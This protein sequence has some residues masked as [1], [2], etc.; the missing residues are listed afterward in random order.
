M[1]ASAPRQGRASDV[2]PCPTRQA[3]MPAR[4]AV[5]AWT[6][7][8]RAPTGPRGASGQPGHGASDRSGCRPDR[9]LARHRSGAW[10]VRLDVAPRPRAR[11]GPG[12]GQHR[13]I[14]RSGTR[15]W[16]S[17]TGASWRGSLS[18]WRRSEPGLPCY[19]VDG[20]RGS[21][22]TRHS[23]TRQGSRRRATRPRAGRRSQ[24]ARHVRSDARRD[25][26]RRRLPRGG[27]DDCRSRPMPVR[28]EPRR[29]SRPRLAPGPVQGTL[30]RPRPCPGPVRQP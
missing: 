30:R 15:D 3:G 23:R 17:G 11:H 5:P 19:T 9:G 20:P 14:R 1:R 22:A 2:R 24:P 25:F 13:D 27:S 29:V 18:V 16:L 28:Y 10:L 12:A 8:C 21:A 7:P 4:S 6:R 26:G